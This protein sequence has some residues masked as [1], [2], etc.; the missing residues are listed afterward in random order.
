MVIQSDKQGK[1]S[2]NA[3]AIFKTLFRAKGTVSTV[4]VK[5]INFFP[6]FY[7]NFLKLT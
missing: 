3:S 6:V 4:V 5:L 1:I 2:E 7:E